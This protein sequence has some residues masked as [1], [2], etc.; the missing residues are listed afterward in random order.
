MQKYKMKSNKPTHNQ[1]RHILPT[2]TTESFTKW[3]GEPPLL[4]L[5][6]QE[7]AQ[8]AVPGGPGGALTHL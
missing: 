2:F 4:I 5:S 1:G 3:G 8:G 6:G 7:L